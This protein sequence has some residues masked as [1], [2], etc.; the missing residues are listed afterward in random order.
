MLNI[1][2]FSD[3]HITAGYNNNK[4]YEAIYRIWQAISSGNIRLQK[5]CDPRPLLDFEFEIISNR[6]RAKFLIHGGDI[7]DTGME[8]DVIAAAEYMKKLFGHC[9][10]NNCKFIAVPGNH[11]RFADTFGSAG[12]TGFEEHILV[13]LD[14]NVLDYGDKIDTAEH[15]WRGRVGHWS[16]SDP[17]QL[18]IYAIDTTLETNSDET[19]RLIGRFGQG[20]VLQDDVQTI[21]FHFSERN[22]IGVVV[23]HAQPDHANLLERAKGSSYLE[24]LLSEINGISI[25]GHTHEAVHKEEGYWMV[26]PGTLSASGAPH[27]YA[28]IS[29][30]I[31]SK[32][33]SV[34]FYTHAPGHGFFKSIQ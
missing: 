7:A 4:R 1:I 33:R 6:H 17:L 28:M 22:Y 27:S 34:T 25:C 16:I 32:T 29:I 8:G 21:K 5:G 19:I 26:N 31:N 11:D 30:D 23:T 12:G 10:R 15:G 24:E 9:R 18:S 14:E 2:A 13:A 20:K 3:T